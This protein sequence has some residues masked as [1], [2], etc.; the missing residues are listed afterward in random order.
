LHLDAAP[1]PVQGFADGADAEADRDETHNVE[2]GDQIRDLETEPRLG[3]EKYAC[4][5]GEGERE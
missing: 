4:T 5:G 3:E 2:A 1:L